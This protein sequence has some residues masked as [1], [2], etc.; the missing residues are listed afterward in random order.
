MLEGAR[1]EPHCGAGG[2]RTA[3]AK[4]ADLGP[5][6]STP[7]KLVTSPGC[8]SPGPGEPLKIFFFTFIDITDY[9]FS[10]WEESVITGLF[11]C[12]FTFTDC[13]LPDKGF[14]Y[15]VLICIFK[16]LW[17]LPRIALAV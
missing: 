17:G 4:K 6:G 9:C 14:M 5:L 12:L 11:L 7:S 3:E 2:A 8:F 13:S 15:I 1:W 16:V 10:L